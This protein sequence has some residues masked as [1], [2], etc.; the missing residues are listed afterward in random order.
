MFARLAH[1]R[2]NWKLTLFT[3][4]MLPVLVALG[5]WQLQREDEKLALQAQYEARQSAAPRPIGQ[6]DG[7]QDLRY[8]PVRATGHFDNE[9]IFLLD[10]RI[11]EGRPGYEVVQPFHTTGSELLL[12]NRGWVE[13]AQY[14][15]ELP[16]IEPVSGQVSI[17]AT[18]YV[19]FGEAFTLG[20]SMSQSSGWPRRI[21]TLE[22]EAMIAQLEGE[23]QDAAFP[24]S[25]RLQPGS[26]GALQENWPPVNTS[27][28]KHQAYAVQWFS[29][30]VVLA[31]LYLY[32]STRREEDEEN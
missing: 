30:A 23:Q 31:G 2:F 28:E 29:M 7:Q 32:V 13:Q 18:V 20:D 19:P 25:L 26:P 12:V 14:R 9:R 4:L 17:R 11:H 24:Y 6:V 5:F 22:P 16:A 8:M 10:N 21:Q 15:S 1:F 3:L 27:P